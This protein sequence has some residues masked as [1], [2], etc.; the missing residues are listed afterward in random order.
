MG[1][2]AL[3]SC[4]HA[5]SPNLWGGD[6]LLEASEPNQGSTFVINISAE[7]LSQEAEL[8]L[9][10]ALPQEMK[11]VSIPVGALGGRRVLLAEDTP[12]QAMLLQILL[13]AQGAQVD[14]VEN[15]A[16]AVEK[17]SRNEY[18]VI[19]MDMQMPVMTGADATTILRQRGYRPPIIA[20]TA[21]AMRS[22]AERSAEAG[23]NEHLT[24]PVSKDE[25]IATIKRVLDAQTH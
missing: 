1:E 19:L 13:S 16:D 24:K 3:D 11:P 10:A 18:D 7:F 5:N 8:V 21:Q 17:A 9:A 2:L 22:D 4:Y 25:L 20:L 15:G 14:I 12:D 23:C 6:V